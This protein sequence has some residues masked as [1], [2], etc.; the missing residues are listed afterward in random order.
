MM[1]NFGVRMKYWLY[2]ILNFFV[3][4]QAHAADMSE[5]LC[6]SHQPLMYNALRFREAGLPISQ[7]KETVSSAIDTDIRL[8]AFLATSIDVAYKDPSLMQKGLDNGN[9]LSACAEHVRG[10]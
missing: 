9:W 4:S 2:F 3:L 1:F 10:Y 5:T 8:Y 7:A 6:R